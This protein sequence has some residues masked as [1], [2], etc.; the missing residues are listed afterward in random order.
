MFD[1]FDILGNL[2]NVTHILNA[3]ARTEVY[4]NVIPRYAMFHV[5]YR[6]DIQPKKK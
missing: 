6:L 4:T 3:Q 2:N 1:G 5:I